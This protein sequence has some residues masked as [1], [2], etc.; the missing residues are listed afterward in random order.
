MLDRY[1]SPPPLLLPWVST[2]LWASGY[3]HSRITSIGSL[4]PLVLYWAWPMGGTS[5]RSESQ[6]RLK[7]GYVFHLPPFLQACW[8]L[9]SSCQRLQSLS[10]S[11]LLHLPSLVPVVLCLPAPSWPR[12]V[13][14]PRL[15]V[16]D[17]C[18][19]L[20]VSLFPDCD[21]AKSSFIKLSSRYPFWVCNLFPFGTWLVQ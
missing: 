15:P 2:R 13:C 6:K 17:Y 11:F 3:W 19:V 18:T 7:S 14:S 4:C 9:T 20:L 12:A 10:G 1:R 8:G 21:S 5:R 16:L